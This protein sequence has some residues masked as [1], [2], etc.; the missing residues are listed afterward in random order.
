MQEKRVREKKRTKP[1][2]TLSWPACQKLT[3]HIHMRGI[4]KPGGGGGGVGTEKTEEKRK[5]KKF[6]KK[7]VFFK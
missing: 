1:K 7:T 5:K 4:K 3:L 6:Q 2:K